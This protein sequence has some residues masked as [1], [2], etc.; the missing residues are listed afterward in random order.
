MCQLKLISIKD[1][2]RW[3]FF[4]KSSAVI[5]ALVHVL[6]WQWIY[7]IHV[8]LFVFLSCVIKF[9][10]LH[11]SSRP[12]MFLSEVFFHIRWYRLCQSRCCFWFSLS[13]TELWKNYCWN[14]IVTAIEWIFYVFFSFCFFISSVH[15]LFPLLLLHVFPVTFLMHTMGVNKQIINSCDYGNP[16]PSSSFTVVISSTKNWVKISLHVERWLSKSTFMYNYNNIIASIVFRI[17][18]DCISSCTPISHIWWKICWW[19]E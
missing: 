6:S 15:S 2:L 19:S 12:C 4:T 14:L 3:V 5:F 17:L 1:L 18:I 7:V 16:P 9:R 10:W 8:F 13:V 11:C